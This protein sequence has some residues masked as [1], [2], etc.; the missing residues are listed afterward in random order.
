VGGIASRALAGSAQTHIVFGLP[1][2]TL[3]DEAH[4]AGVVAAALFGEGM[5]SPLLDQIRERRGLAYY[6][7]C[8]AD[9]SEIAGQFVIEASTAPEHADEFL[10]EVKRLLAAQVEGVEQVDLERAK[11]QIAVRR[12]RAAERPSR[13]LEDAALDLLSLGRVRPHSELAERTEAVTALDVRHAFAR[14]LESRQAV[15]L[16]GK[17]R[18]GTLERVR[19]IFAAR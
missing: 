12:L 8:S 18:K 9:V 7:S 19:E 1:M 4:H 10:V 15:A 17:I 6:L 2:P 14:M 5:S 13:R 16:A 3:K 11:N